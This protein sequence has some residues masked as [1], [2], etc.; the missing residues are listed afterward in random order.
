MGLIEKIEIRREIRRDS[1]LHQAFEYPYTENDMMTTLPSSPRHIHD[2]VR[3]EQDGRLSAISPVGLRGL[4]CVLQ[5]CGGP[6]P[7]FPVP[8]CCAGAQHCNDEPI[9]TRADGDAFRSAGS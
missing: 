5:D 8:D 3:R 4:C 1:F 6:P 7:E 2:G 9:P